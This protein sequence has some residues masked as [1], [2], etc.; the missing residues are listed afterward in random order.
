MARKPVKRPRRMGKYI[1]GN[2]DENLDLGTLAGRTLISTTFDEGPNERTLVSSIVGI[3]SLA[4]FTP[5][6][7]CGPIW[8]GVAHG[9]YTDAEIEEVLENL[10]SWNEGDLVSQEKAN[11]KV[12]KVGVFQTPQPN[13]TGAY[14]LNDGKPIKTKLNWVLLQAQSLKLW[15]YNIGSASVATTDPNVNLAGHANLWPR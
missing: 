10:G 5:V 2:V 14:V 11:R 6:A 7:E 8:V 3:W 12:R 4:N 13:A 15:A 9:D 1:K